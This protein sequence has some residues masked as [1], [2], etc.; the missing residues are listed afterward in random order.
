MK[1]TLCTLNANGLRAADK[2]GFSDW[3]ERKQP[4]VLCLQELR[5]LPEQVKDHV[6]SPPGYNTR[7]LNAEKKGY[8]GVAV[9]ARDAADAYHEGCGLDWAD[10]EGRVLRA[11]FPDWTVVSTYVPSGSSSEERQA[12]KFAFL[13]HFPTY[14][15][16]LLALDRPVAICGDVNI[17]HSELDIWAPKRNEKNSGFLPEEREW[18]T[19]F[20]DAGWTDVFRAQN[21]DAPGLYS[22]W[23]NRGQAREKDRGWRLDYVLANPA[24]TERVTG[25]WIEKEAGLS[26]HAPVWVEFETD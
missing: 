12:K 9:F 7:W 8:S 25:S 22:W 24:F 14:A 23:S 3:L 6:R 10:S 26:D 11:D 13:E 4:D 21:G 5:A 19:G 2:R 15:K 1:R 17:A 20:L 18:L 16:E